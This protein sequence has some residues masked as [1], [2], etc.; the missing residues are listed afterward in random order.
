MITRTPPS[1][2]HVAFTRIPGREPIEFVA[3]YPEFRDYY[4]NCELQTKR[5]FIENVGRDW[6]IF[7]VGANVGYYSILFSQLAPEGQIYAFEPTE[8]ISMLQRNLAHAGCGNVACLQ[9]ALAARVG[10]FEDDIF[11]IWGKDAERRTFTFSSVDAIVAKLGLDRLD[12]IKID[13]DSYDLDVL[14]GARHTL[15]RL[16]PWVVVELNHALAKRGHGVGEA[17]EWL[18]SRGYDKALVLDGEN[19]ALH[20]TSGAQQAPAERPSIEVSFETRPVFLSETLKKTTQ[21]SLF[22]M[23]PQCHAAG[24]CVRTPAG[25][26]VIGAPGPRW[27]YAVTWPRAAAGKIET[28]MAIVEVKLTVSGGTVSLGCLDSSFNAYCTAEEN[29]RPG[30][31]PVTVPIAI[32]E[33]A[34]AAHLVLRNTDSD[35]KD[36]Q[37]VVHAI[38]CHAAA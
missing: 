19:F 21:L 34:N 25:T 11:R 12:C 27:S 10:K 29:V 1:N 38:D 13:V 6:H 28:G 8:T 16:N 15:D 3:F 23:K 30:S 37:V 33:V 18:A 24:S 36:A 4:R 5:W 32:E 17:L 35:G 20:R 31:D 2:K 26:Y 7:D 9:V 22:E 14:W